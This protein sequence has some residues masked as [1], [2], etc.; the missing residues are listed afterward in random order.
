MSDRAVALHCSEEELNALIRSL[1]LF[2]F[3]VAERRLVQDP[4]EDFRIC[5]YDPVEDFSSWDDGHVFCSTCEVRWIR[6]ENSFQLVAIGDVPTTPEVAEATCERKEIGEGAPTKILL[7]GIR[8]K[9]EPDE[10]W[11]ARIPRTFRYPV[12]PK[13]DATSPVRP[14]LT[15]VEY[16]DPESDAVLWWRCAGLTSEEE[17]AYA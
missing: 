10:W 14:W 3:M 4:A 15:I 8:D 5:E 6:R 2:E 7:W 11:Q 1:G 16:R 9:D 12:E 13:N 17:N